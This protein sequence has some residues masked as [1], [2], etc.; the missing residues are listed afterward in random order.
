MDAL[1]RNRCE[2]EFLT[3][4]AHIAEALG[5]KIRFEASIPAEGGFRDI[6]RVA[7]DKDN[8]AMSVSAITAILTLLIT[9]SVVI[10]NSPPRPNPELERQQLEVGKLTAEHMRLENQRSA[11]EIKKART[12]NSQGGCPYCSP[13]DRTPIRER[14]DCSLI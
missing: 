13:A 3:A 5:A 10:W 6:W 9:Q 8:R 7:F 11:L 12:R 14:L 1:V 2:A 4:V